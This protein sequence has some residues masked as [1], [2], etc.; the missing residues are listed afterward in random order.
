MKAIKEKQESSKKTV[1]NVSDAF[2]EV[3]KGRNGKDY[4]VLVL[5]TEN[6]NYCFF[7]SFKERG[8]RE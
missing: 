2:V 4:C 8:E 1:I 6:G 3:R 7:P 5:E